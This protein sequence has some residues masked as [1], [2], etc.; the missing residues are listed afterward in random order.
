MLA[1]IA[2]LRP[3]LERVAVAGFAAFCLC[4]V[5]AIQP[6]EKAV[7]LLPGFSVVHNTRMTILYLLCAGLLAGWGLDDLTDPAVERRRWAVPAAAVALVL[8]VLWVV[9]GGKAGLEY[10]GDGLEVAW[11]FA[12]P[13][14]PPAP[15]DSVIWSAVLI[16]VV[17]AGAAV[18]LLH[19][20]ARGRLA[21]AAFTALALLVVAAD[22]FRAGMGQNTA[23]TLDEARQPTPGSIRYLQPRTPGRF[24]GAER[25]A[26]PLAPEPEPLPPTP[27]CATACSTRA[28][29]TT[30]SRAATT[31][32]GSARSSPRSGS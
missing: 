22:L 6:I 29:T 9:V 4:L 2:L 13:A 17:F 10:L 16:W 26:D 11:G 8:P 14:P 3:T 15:G 24:V 30:R 21:V 31:S 28:A 32:C 12:T 5:F 7:T 27:T 23:I 1:V 18:L 25:Q 19:L 20:R